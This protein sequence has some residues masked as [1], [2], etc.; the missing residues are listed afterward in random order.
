MNKMTDLPRPTESPSLTTYDARDLIK[1][2]SQICILLDNQQY[3]LR[4]TRA[5][6]L[7]L[8]K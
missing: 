1:D 4:I 8:T 3:F 2:A 7:I 6:K 5:G